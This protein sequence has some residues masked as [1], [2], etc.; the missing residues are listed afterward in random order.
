VWVNKVQQMFQVSNVKYN[1]SKKNRNWGVLHFT[2]LIGLGGSLCEN[3][4]TKNGGERGG[5][6]AKY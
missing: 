4:C 5:I 3:V 1:E 6:Q 2:K